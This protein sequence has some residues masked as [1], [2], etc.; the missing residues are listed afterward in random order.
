MG[1]GEQAA[2]SELGADYER[3]GA[4]RIAELVDDEEGPLAAGDLI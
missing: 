1:D 4:N 2:S 3:E